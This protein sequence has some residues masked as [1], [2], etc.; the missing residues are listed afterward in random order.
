MRI[1]TELF[2]VA[3]VATLSGVPPT[4]PLAAGLLPQDEAASSTTTIALEIV[5]VAGERATVRAK[6]RGRATITLEG[7]GAVAL[8][9]SL[10]GQD[11][12]V[13]FTETW[14]VHTSVLP[15]RGCNGDDGRGQ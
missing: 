2:V 5:T 15:R 4:M 9:P 10:H 8:T 3:A 7:T 1:R 11:L 12:E 14:V 13:R 6:D